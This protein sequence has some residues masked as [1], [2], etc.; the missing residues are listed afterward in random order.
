[1]F[2]CIRS[3][4]G[5]LIVVGCASGTL[6]LYN[7]STC[8]QLSSVLAHSGAVTGVAFSADDRQVLSSGEDGCVVMWNVFR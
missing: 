5:E 4:D 6:A 3:N 7:F 8:Q 2:S 1:M